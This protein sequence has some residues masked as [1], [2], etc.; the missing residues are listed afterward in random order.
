MHHFSYCKNEYIPLSGVYW[1]IQLEILTAGFLSFKHSN[2]ALIIQQYIILVVYTAKNVHFSFEIPL[3][4]TCR[5]RLAQ[6][7]TGSNTID[8]EM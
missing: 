3:Q 2:E 6:T 1:F 8:P 7:P 5:G 4:Q